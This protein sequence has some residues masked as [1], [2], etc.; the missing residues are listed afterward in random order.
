[1]LDI[2]EIAKG[3]SE[4][5]RDLWIRTV[6]TVGATDAQ[7]RAF[8]DGYNGFDVPKGASPQMRQSHS[9]GL[10]VRAH[11]QEKTR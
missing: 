7:R 3:L 5:D 6:L 1:M 9:L 8:I 2:S 11:L 4:A 10:Q